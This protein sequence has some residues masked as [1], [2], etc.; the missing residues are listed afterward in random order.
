MYQNVTG[1]LLHSLTALHT[2]HTMY[3]TL[4]A[5]LK[6]KWPKALPPAAEVAAAAAPVIAPPSPPPN[7]AALPP[8]PG[9]PPMHP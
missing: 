7:G 2:I 6:K 1:C 4:I 5:W 8:P 3:P 9:C